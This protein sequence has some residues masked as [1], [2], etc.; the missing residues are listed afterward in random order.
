VGDAF[1]LSIFIEHFS[2]FN[3]AAP[4]YGLIE[5][6]SMK[7]DKAKMNSWTLTP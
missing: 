7:I 3:D 4:N 2:F 1:D 6:C 5:K